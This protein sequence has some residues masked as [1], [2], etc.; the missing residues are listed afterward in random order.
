MRHWD[1]LKLT[2]GSITEKAMKALLGKD[3]SECNLVIATQQRF[4]HGFFS[5][6]EK[7]T[8]CCLQLWFGSFS[9]VLAVSAWLSGSCSSIHKTLTNYIYRMRGMLPVLLLKISTVFFPC[10]ISSEAAV[11]ALFFFQNRNRNKCIMF[12]FF[13]AVFLFFTEFL[14][15]L[16][17]EMWKNLDVSVR[18][19]LWELWEL[20][21]DTEM[22][23][24]KRAIL[25][26]WGPLRMAILN[27]VRIVVCLH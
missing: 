13:I 6:S 18:L 16:F 2:I 12:F 17:C 15:F 3:V 23:L 25:K 24:Q 1:R 8:Q 9:P 27:Y 4:Q 26:V 10:W 20:N 5:N 7:V 22:L 14:P 11:E 21:C 19:L